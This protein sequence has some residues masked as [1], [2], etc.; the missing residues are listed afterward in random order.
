MLQS[1]REEL[2]ASLAHLAQPHSC[3]LMLA[4]ESLCCPLLLPQ[5][6]REELLTSL[7]ASADLGDEVCARPGR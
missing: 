3:S 4:S 6:V 5:S 7:D 2:L 1:V